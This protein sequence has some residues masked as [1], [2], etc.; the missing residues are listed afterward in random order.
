MAA[1]RHHSSSQA[2]KQQRR[3]VIVTARRK[4]AVSRG[5][6]LLTN[7][8]NGAGHSQQNQ[9]KNRTGINHAVT[10]VGFGMVDHGGT[11]NCD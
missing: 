11:F 1:L 3:A 6:L 7:P 10:L 8:E 4:S 9:G 5:I 2:Q